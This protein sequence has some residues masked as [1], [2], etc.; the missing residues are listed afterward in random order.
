M[1]INPNTIERL[2]REI[3]IGRVERYGLRNVIKE[4]SAG[5]YLIAECANEQE[6]NFYVE[7]RNRAAEIVTALRELADAKRLMGERYGIPML[8]GVI[9]PRK[10][11]ARAVHNLLDNCRSAEEERDALRTKVKQLQKT[12]QAVVDAW[13]PDAEAKGYQKGIKA[14]KDALIFETESRSVGAIV[15]MKPRAIYDT[16][17]ALLNNNDIE[18]EK[19]I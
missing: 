13:G 3:I 15:P 16:L 1:T 5:S 14:A 8:P 19:Q 2:A 7:V 18:D 9:F 10:D 4:G 12:G 6:A 17:H 11:D